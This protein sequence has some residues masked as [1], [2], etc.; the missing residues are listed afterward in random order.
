MYLS[1]AGET[2]KTVP[3]VAISTL[4][5]GALTGVAGTSFTIKT[6][7][8]GTLTTVG[9]GSSKALNAAFA[10]WAIAEAADGGYTIDIADSLLAA[11]V[12]WAEAIVTAANMVPVHL[13]FWLPVQNPFAAGYSLNDLNEAAWDSTH[14]GGV[15]GDTPREAA[16]LWSTD[17][18]GAN[19]I[20]GGGTQNAPRLLARSGGKVRIRTTDQT[21]ATVV[22]DTSP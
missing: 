16:R 1:Y 7:R 8:A 14:N 4:T 20:A 12:Q 5:G 11:G 6:V 22:V 15:D 18:A 19:D 13:L 10:A 2:S 9:A 17:A 3:F 21:R